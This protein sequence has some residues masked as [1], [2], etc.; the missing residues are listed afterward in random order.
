[1]CTHYKAIA[2]CLMIGVCFGCKSEVSSESAAQAPQVLV[3]EVTQQ[4]V[5]IYAEWVGSTDGTVNASIRAQVTGYLLKRNYV[6]GA[7]VKKGDVLFEIDPRKFQA[8]VDQAKG[9]LEQARA[10]LLKT[11]LEV[12][13]DTPLAKSGA[14][15]QKELD[16]SIQD[17]AAG[18]SERCCLSVYYSAAGTIS[19]ERIGGAGRNRTAA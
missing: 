8:A 11:E 7:F 17:H 4:D 14:V 18:E 6:E 15:S 19:T 3:A 13:R 10:Q 5:P 2:A 9:Q 16:D 1:M 12:K